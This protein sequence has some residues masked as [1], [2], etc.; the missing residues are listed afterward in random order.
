MNT[1]LLEQ[2]ENSMNKNLKRTVLVLVAAL[3]VLATFSACDTGMFLDNELWG[4]WDDGYGTKM[5]FTNS[6]FNFDAQ[7]AEYFGV[8]YEYDYSGDVVSYNNLSYNV[9]AENPTEGNYGHMILKITAHKEDSTQEGTYTVIRWR[10][11]KTENDVTTVE[12]SEAYPAG[13]ASAEAAAEATEDVNFLR[14][15]TITLDVE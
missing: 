3:M 14:Y 8:T 1:S 11:L 15:S 10:N 7:P 5:T 6:T 13:F 9:S 2:K 4:T 12:Y